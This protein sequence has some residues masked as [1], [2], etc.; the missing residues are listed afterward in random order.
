VH[1]FRSRGLIRIVDFH[2]AYRNTVAVDGLSFTVG[3]G[4]IL[5]LVGPNGAGK[6]TTMR[7]LAGILPPTR[8]SLFVGD[9]DVVANPLEAKRRLAYV[10]DDPRLFD[11]LTVYE[12]L[13]FT[14]SAYGISA[15]RDKADR[16]L[17]MFE[18]CEKRDAMA[19]ELSRGMRQ[20]VAVACAYLP[21]PDAILFDEPLTGLD[22]KGIRTLKQTI[23]DRAA[24]GAAII[25]SSH[26][27]GLVEDL[28]TH[29]LVLNRGK[30]LF[31]GSV[32]EVHATLSSQQ[33]DTSLE[34]IF[35]EIIQ[36]HD[37]VA[38]GSL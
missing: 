25:I 26:L 37:L 22:P 21:D 18:L 3:P 32:E 24:G 16:L 5:A 13:D 4:E 38:Q 10:P 6:T 12:H 34:N 7:T 29:L 2:K 15:Y 1:S 19:S 20:K 31:C 27:L 8:G 35:F 28:C 30:A 33:T 11:A 17:E 23:V 14:A 36:N 9:S